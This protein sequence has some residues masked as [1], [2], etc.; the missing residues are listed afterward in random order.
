MTTALLTA[1]VLATPN[2]PA[3]VSRL[4]GGPQPSCAVCHVGPTQRG[5]VTTPLGKALRDR[6]LVANDVPSL[7]AAVSS[8]GQTDSDGDGV[9]D[10]EELKA[11][12]DPNVAGVKAPPE[13]SYGCAAA[14][15]SGLGLWA[16]WVVMAAH[17]RRGRRSGP[18][19]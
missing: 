10:L 12:E 4:T 13:P 3:E 6:G 16:V 8:L 5:T 15:W 11:G 1:L 7:E 14:P 18:P 9:G 2:F 19:V 17:G